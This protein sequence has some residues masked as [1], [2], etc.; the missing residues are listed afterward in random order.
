[1]SP[2]ALWNECLNVWRIAKL[3]TS[4]EHVRRSAGSS[5]FAHSAVSHIACRPTTLIHSSF[6]VHC[7]WECC[8]VTGITFNMSTMWRFGNQYVRWTIFTPHA[9]GRRCRV[10]RVGKEGATSPSSRLTSSKF[11]HF[12]HKSF[13]C[14]MWILLTAILHSSICHYPRIS[15]V[16]F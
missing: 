12:I 13:P 14:F 6:C 10:S 4:L 3:G 2:V 8:D 16:I 5:D 11:W 15:V 9:T 7:G 1:M